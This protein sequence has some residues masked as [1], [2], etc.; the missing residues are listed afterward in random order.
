[1]GDDDTAPELLKQAMVDGIDVSGVVRRRGTSTGLIVDVVDPAGQWRY[2][3]DLSPYV[4]LTETDVIA[5]ELLSAAIVVRADARE[6][7]LLAGTVV[8]SPADARRAGP[9]PSGRVRA[10]SRSP[11]ATKATTS[12][13]GGERTPAAAD[14]LPCHGH[15][16]RG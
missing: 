5:A 11:S 1:V 6:A 15:D 3:E 10:W 8:D 2:L 12:P 9:R 16:R 4:L 7:S 14:R 13:A